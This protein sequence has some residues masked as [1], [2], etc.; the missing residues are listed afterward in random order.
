[1]KFIFWK[2]KDKGFTIIE[3]IVSITIIAMV[4]GIFLAN[5]HD[6]NKKTALALAAQKLVT[7]IRLAQNYS[8]STRELSAGVSVPGGWGIRAS[9]ASPNN[10]FYVI[11]ADLNS[12]K[13]YSV[14][15]FYR[16][17][18]LP[19]NVTI[20]SITPASPV[21]IVFLPP[22]PVTYVNNSSS[23]SASITLRDSDGNTK[24]VT[25]NF[26]GLIDVN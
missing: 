23:A 16:R 21:E 13:T 9:S 8:L 1:M 4:T 17:V 12:D 3:L 6:T 7:D 15:E 25:A 2:I 26:L 5:Y 14:D 19:A 20:S 11:F 10:T 22:D 24:I 18:D